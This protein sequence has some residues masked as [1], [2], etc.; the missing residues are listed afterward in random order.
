M[1]EWEKLGGSP[2]PFR[3]IAGY[4]NISTPLLDMIDTARSMQ[5][6]IDEALRY[7]FLGEPMP[8]ERQLYWKKYATFGHSD[9]RTLEHSEHP[10]DERYWDANPEPMGWLADW[11]EDLERW[12]RRCDDD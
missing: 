5:T 7:S 4:V 6:Y 8:F 3:T 9:D 11:V 12:P 2:W 10:S 1:S